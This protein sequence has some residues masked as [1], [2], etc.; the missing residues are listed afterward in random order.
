MTKIIDRWIIK[1]DWSGQEHLVPAADWSKPRRNTPI[2]EVIKQ[3][4]EKLFE[5]VYLSLL[6]P[7]THPDSSLVCLQAIRKH[8]LEQ[9]SGTNDQW[10]INHFQVLPQSLQEQ[11]LQKRDASA[12][13]SPPPPPRVAT[14]VLSP[15]PHPPVRKMYEKKGGGENKEL[16]SVYVAETKSII[17]HTKQHRRTFATKNKQKHSRLGR[18]GGA[19]LDE[20]QDQNRVVGEQPNFYQCSERQF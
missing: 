16:A 13:L 17:A 7:T 6:P 15:P 4:N 20:L 19:F 8:R 11:T 14:V 12:V 1:K 5:N 10:S 3:T 2:F 18:G 9:H